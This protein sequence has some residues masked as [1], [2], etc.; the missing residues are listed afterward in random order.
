MILLKPYKSYY[1]QFDGKNTDI[2]GEIPFDLP[3]G[4][5]W[6]RLKQLFSV[7]SARRVHKA[8]WKVAGIPFYRAREV[9][10][11]SETGFVNN[12]LFIS[13]EQYTSYKQSTGVPLP[14]DLMVT[15]VG[16]IGKVYVVKK[17]DIFYYKDASVIC[18]ENRYHINPYFYKNLFSTSFMISQVHKN[19]T[20]S[21]V[22]TMTIEKSEQYLLPLPPLT[23]QKRIVAQIESL[24]KCVDEIDRESETLEKS[25]TLAKQK[26]LD[27]AIRGKLVPQDPK[28]E[29]ASELLKKV[30]AEK[31][32]LIKAGKLK[33]DKHESF[34]FRDDDNCY[35]EN[36][37]GKV[38]D[39]TDEIPF[40]LAN[41]WSWCRLNNVASLAD[42]DWIESKDQAPT[43]FRLIQTGNIGKCVF[44]PHD[45]RARYISQETFSNLNCTEIFPGDCLISRLP[46]PLGR[47]C[48]IPDL[49][50]RMITA[51]DC[52]ITRPY[53]LGLSSLYFMYF[54]GTTIYNE[55]VEKN[56]T[57][58][59][60]K[61]ISRA[62]LDKVLI[63]LPPI[64]EQKRIVSQV[65]KLFSVLE[66]MR[67]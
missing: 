38:T 58:S 13:E 49:Q 64:A 28:D 66:T 14:G 8:D 26:I 22:D 5:M 33:R 24:M 54:T 63:P 21:T 25:L 43:G 2:F 53:K 40:E 51:V 7:V 61:R 46:D 11:L 29:P 41:G 36:I 55:Y 12:D 19:S 27:L 60:R 31:E 62:N 20:G 9:A 45:E 23:E 10:K 44:L 47:S 4:W 15:A 65:E 59:T 6:A 56:A 37:D 48:I 52:T 39:I 35:H 34:I 16:T 17:G 57:G 18:F 32:A 30:K 42:G 67:G 1:E 3:N 50:E